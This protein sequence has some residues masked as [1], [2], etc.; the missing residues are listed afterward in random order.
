MSKRKERGPKLRAGDWMWQPMVLAAEKGASSADKSVRC[1]GN[2]WYQVVLRVRP[3]VPP[4]VEVPIAQLSIKRW[5]REQVFEWRDLQRIKDDIL[6]TGIEAMQLFPASDRIVDTANQYHLWALPIGMTFG[7]GYFDGRL[8][9]ADPE[10]QDMLDKMDESLRNRPDY[11]G[12]KQA[13]REEHHTDE[14]LP[15]VGLAGEWWKPFFD[16]TKSTLD[17]LGMGSV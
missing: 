16:P 3:P 2:A 12:A 6:G 13:P 14:G 5:D 9:D 8:T 7:V 10:T 15:N 4:A 17:D 1:W 11:V